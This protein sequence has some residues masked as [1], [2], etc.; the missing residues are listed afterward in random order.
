MMIRALLCL[1]A[2]SASLFA[3]TIPTV[4]L[5]LDTSK[6]HI[7]FPGGNI[8]YVPF[9]RKLDSLVY[10]GKGNINILHL[11][12]SHIQA[13]VISNRVRVHLLQDLK[14]PAA[15]RGFVFPYTAARTSTPIS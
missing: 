4:N 3:D 8:S 9:L 5:P 2:L 15:S 7:E 10:T 6:N 11:G 13:D 12:G 1:F 14:L